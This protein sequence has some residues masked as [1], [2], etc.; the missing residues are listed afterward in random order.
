MSGHALTTQLARPSR[1]ATVAA[2]LLSL[3]A[4]ALVSLALMKTAGSAESGAARSW[5]APDRAFTLSVPPGWHA[6]H[7]AQL[8]VLPSRPAAL[9]RRRDGRGTVSV[10]SGPPLRGTRGALAARLARQLGAR[11]PGFQPVGARFARVRGGRAF[12]FTFVHGSERT[13]QSL[14]LV[15]AGERSYAIDAVTAGDAPDVARQAAAIVT[16]FG[17]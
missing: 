9:L 6:A 10:R 17:P 5:T 4:G 7:A 12:V 14:T 15:S 2:V 3:L 11:F 1:A 16:S 8:A 13:V